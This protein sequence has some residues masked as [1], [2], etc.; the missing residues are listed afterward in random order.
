M[1]I[2]TV[3]QDYE[4]QAR[5]GDESRTQPLM[6]AI[7]L[8]ICTL[9][10]S[11][12]LKSFVVQIFTVPSASM[13]PTLEIGD[14]IAVARILTQPGMPQRGDV[15]VFRDPGKWLPQHPKNRSLLLRAFEF[16]GM[17]PYHSDEHLVKR[18]VGE[19]GDV[20]ECRGSGPLYVNGVAAVEPFVAPGVQ[21]CGREFK[22]AVPSRSVW[23]MGDNRDN[24]ADSR[25]HMQ[26]VR[27]GSVPLSLVVGEVVFTVWPPNHWGWPSS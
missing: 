1:R 25:F 21:P 11:L 19:A 27:H 17:I 10:L 13:V 4:P 14:K 26:D 5:L 3:V 12:F 6:Q 18:V 16:V 7:F 24:S 2:A 22:V 20:V 8:V 15:I 23:V 9:S